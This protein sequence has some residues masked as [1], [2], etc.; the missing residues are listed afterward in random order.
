V[1]LKGVNGAGDGDGEG[2]GNPEPAGEEVVGVAVR[3][4]LDNGFGA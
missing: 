1:N 4:A 3:S 2:H